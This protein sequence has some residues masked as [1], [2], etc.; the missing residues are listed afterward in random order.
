MYHR[1]VADPGRLTVVASLPPLAGFRR[2]VAVEGAK[3]RAV[4]LSFAPSEI[5]GDP[6]RRAV[7]LRA[8]DVAARLHDRSVAAVLGTGAVDGAL[9][10]VEEYRPGT[11]LRA[12][13]DAAGRT[14]PDVAARIGIEVAAALS[15]AHEVVAEGVRVAHGALD[16]AR[17]AIA[18]S[19]EVSIC[20]LALVPGAEP[21]G[22]LRA[23]GAV[24]HE[25]LAG[26]P[27]GDP[28]RKLDVPGVPAALAAA[29][30]R[31]C[32]AAAPPWSGPAALAGAISEAVATPA[33][34]SGVAAYADAI[35]PADE[36]ERAAL[37]AMLATALDRAVGPPPL[38][39]LPAAASEPIAP[40]PPRPRTPDSA[41]TAF[42]RPAPSAPLR[43]S[44]IG[45]VGVVALAVGFGIGFGAQRALRPAAAPAA[46]AP[47]LPDAT[48]AGA[49]SPAPV[50]APP[51]A[52]PLPAAL[53]A[54]PAPA[55]PV[56]RP[57]KRAAPAPRAAAGK[58]TLDVT[59]PPDA[60]VLLDGKRIGRGNVH[61]EVAV[62][63]H[64]I[65]GPARR[66]GGPRAVHARAGR[67]LDLRGDADAARGDPRRSR[68]RRDEGPL[69]ATRARARRRAR[70]HA[71]R[72]RGRARPH[73]RAVRGRG[74]G[75]APR[76]SRRG[77]HG[78]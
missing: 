39:S 11:T 34:A 69:A 9:A 7:L 22:D 29:V 77:P 66:R 16:A 67:D 31:A 30:D 65:R 62:G 75:R 72:G 40:A 61:V 1:G 8:V 14:P 28:P 43:L 48:P 2:A 74:R 35:V 33:T 60:E 47:Q 64:R 13:L 20:G 46:I 52:A 51:A 44:I 17:I 59:A 78:R 58:G 71:A 45:A 70:G 5:A 55:R 38:T 50:V 18:E 15:R 26:E 24:L 56:T 4:V 68:G 53:P 6:A 32:G 3:R 25:C 36:G 21:A 63:A 19:G 57:G 41:R 76:P 23:I 49:V 37:R 12:L 27:P 73:G 10:V 54:A 42:P